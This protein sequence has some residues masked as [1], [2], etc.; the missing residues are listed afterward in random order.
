LKAGNFIDV[1]VAPYPATGYFPEQ[2]VKDILING[3]VPVPRPILPMLQY[4]L[5]IPYLI[6]IDFGGI[7][8][9][10]PQIFLLKTELF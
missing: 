4:L 5:T 8:T 6:T 1:N 9:E 3:E 7:L 10:E 2:L